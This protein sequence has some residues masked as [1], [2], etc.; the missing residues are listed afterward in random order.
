MNAGYRVLDHTAD[1]YLSVWAED[2]E[3]LLAQAAEAL[4]GQVVE[5]QSVAESRCVEIM[6]Q[7]SDPETLLLNWLRELLFEIFTRGHLFR[8]FEV[9]VAR[10]TLSSDSDF[11][12]TAHCYGESFDEKRHAICTEVKAVTRHGLEVR[13]LGR[14]WEAKVLLDV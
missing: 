13:D 7:A 10:Q 4:Q 3:G 9:Q 14:R 6:V 5:M 2:F 11:V 12:L 8:R 1:L